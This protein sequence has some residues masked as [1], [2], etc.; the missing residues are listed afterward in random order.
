MTSSGR[1]GNLLGGKALVTG[2][3]LIV[4]GNLVSLAPGADEMTVGTK[5]QTLND[6][7]ATQQ[8]LQIST[9]SLVDFKVSNLSSI[10]GN[11]MNTPREPISLAPDASEVFIGSKKEELQGPVL[12]R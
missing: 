2:S 7:Q 12:K 1:G 4:S 3:V 6:S 9:D 11:T 5:L 8:M 10:I